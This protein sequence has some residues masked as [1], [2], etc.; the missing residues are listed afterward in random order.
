MKLKTAGTL[1][2]CFVLLAGCGRT[3]EPP[4][5]AEPAAGTGQENAMIDLWEQ[6]EIAFGILVPNEAPPPPPGEGRGRGRGSRPPA[7][8]TAQGGEALAR[9]P[10]YDFVFLNLEGGYDAGAISAI[11][12]GLRSPRAVSRK[13]LLVRIPPI[14]SEDAGAEVTRARV[15]EALDLG[16]DGVVL[17]HVR[18]IEEVQ[19]A[20]SFFAEAGADVWSPSNPDG[21]VLAM[22]MLEDPAA[23]ADAAAIADLGGYSALSCGCGSLGGAIRRELMGDA[24]PA[25]L[26]DE[27]REAIGA[28]A[29]AAA[30]EGNQKVLREARRAGLANMTVASLDDIE[31]RV[32]EGFSAFV[33]LR[34]ASDADPIIELGRTTAGHQ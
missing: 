15:K 17:P 1:A 32:G 28:E 2:V 34:P 10:L 31:Q 30:E 6:N 29:R 18:N 20:V 5:E 19:L 3:S 14:S 9:S 11:S 13:T 12:E 26:S 33:M 27:D 8:Y 16:A 22:L 7:F 23:V 24:D 21:E 25:S 4:A